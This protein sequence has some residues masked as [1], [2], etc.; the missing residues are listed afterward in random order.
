MN[1]SSILVV[2]DDPNNFDVIE[3]FLSDPEYELHY[4]DSGAEAIASLESYN[5]DLIL[6]DVMMPG[7]DGIEVC[8]QIKA[9]TKWQAIP[10]I[11]VTALDSK[12]DLARCLNA[13]AE[14]FLSKP[15]NVLE[16]RARVNAMLRIK[17]QYDE[18]QNLLKLREDMVQMLV[19]DLRNPLTGLLLNFELL[20]S[21]DY[22]KEKHP[23]KIDQM[24]TSAKILDGLVD[25][26][27]Q[28]ALM[29]SGKLLLNCTEV[30][31]GD[32]IQSTPAKF[33]AIC[34]QKKQSIIIQLP[35]KSSIKI[36]VD[37]PLFQRV[38]DN[39]ISNAIKFSPRNS[40]III[41]AE[42]LNSGLVKIQ[43]IDSGPG[44]TDELKKTIFEKYEIG[45]KMNEISQI[46]L[47]LAFCKMVVEAHQGQIQVMNNQPKGSIFEI[48]LGDH[49]SIGVNLT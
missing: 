10:I 41:N 5:P 44:V 21:E 20:R 11:M 37:A 40:Q 15:V 31:I 47:G 13:G 49:E 25:D 43:V 26:L 6:L 46:G 33:E 23:D 9:M 17:Q 34:A 19:H 29:E 14:D 12:P 18:L 30:D 28:I 42:L 4:A 45:T 48:T 2:D 24:Y 8:R 32:L 16:L 39:L 7:I 27:L 35:E 1:P 22:P 3:T 36:S 38:I